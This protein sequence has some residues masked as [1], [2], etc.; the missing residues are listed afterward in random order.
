[1]ILLK[2][3]KLEIKTGCGFDYYV[4]SKEE[5]INSSKKLINM[6]NSITFINNTGSDEPYVKP[7]LEEIVKNCKDL[8]DFFDD[9]VFE[10]FKIYDVYH[11]QCKNYFPNIDVSI[12][13]RVTIIFNFPE[14]QLEETS[15]LFLK[16]QSEFMY[17]RCK[18]YWSKNSKT[19]YIYLDNTEPIFISNRLEKLH[20]FK[21]TLQLF[22]RDLDY[23]H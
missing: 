2:C 19:A 13:Y 6:P 8:N 17:M 21:N 4:F 3:L 5:I 10:P 18:F 9:K 14:S 22:Y 16:K 23:K 11:S 7:T 1:M 12:D 20:L 15:E